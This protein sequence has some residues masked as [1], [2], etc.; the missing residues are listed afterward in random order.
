MISENVRNICVLFSH[1]CMIVEC[2]LNY[3]YKQQ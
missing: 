1:M 3:E 2:A